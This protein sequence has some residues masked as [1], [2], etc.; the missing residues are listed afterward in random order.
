[1]FS[2][3][4]Y[5]RLT[6]AFAAFV[7][8]PGMRWHCVST[9]MTRLKIMPSRSLSSINRSRMPSQLRLRA[10]LSSVMK[11]RRIPRLRCA[12]TILS[13]SSALLNRDV[14]PW[15]LMIVQKLHAK[16]QPRP[17]SKLAW[18]P[19]VRLTR[20]MDRIGVGTPASI[21]GSARPLSTARVFDGIADRNQLITYP[22][23]S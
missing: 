19:A 5:T 10:K 16:G 2:S 9:W 21:G 13:T 7:T 3:P 6:P 22:S 20:S 11:R 14:R 8:K 17:A 15:T 12:R 18:A 23:S 4:M 1:M